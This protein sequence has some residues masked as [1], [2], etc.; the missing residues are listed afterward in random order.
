MDS[1]TN[2]KNTKIDGFSTP[3]QTLKQSTIMNI[4]TDISTKLM[5]AA[6]KNC[7]KSRIREYFN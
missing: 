2:S 3:H 1:L 6:L 4:D 5:I 7:F